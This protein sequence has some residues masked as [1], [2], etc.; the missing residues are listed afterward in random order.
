MNILL[1]AA[2]GMMSGCTLMLEEGVGSPRSSRCGRT[3]LPRHNAAAGAAG[4]MGGPHLEVPHLLRGPAT[5]PV[6]LS[7]HCCPL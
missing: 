1:G 4:G 2:S 5:P 7:C 6:L 3:P